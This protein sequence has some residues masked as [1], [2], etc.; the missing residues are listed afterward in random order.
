MLNIFPDEYLA[1]S[2]KTITSAELQPQLLCEEGLI[3]IGNGRRH[4]VLSFVIGA[5]ENVDLV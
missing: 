1:E 5:A 2:K 3:Q 4:F